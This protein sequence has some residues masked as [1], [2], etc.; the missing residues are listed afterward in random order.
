M[1]SR[2][3]TVF[4][5]PDTITISSG[6]Q[7]T[8][9]L[10]CAPNARNNRDLDITITYKAPSEKE[11]TT[12]QYKMCVFC[13]SPPSADFLLGRSCERT[14][15]NCQVLIYLLSSDL[16]CYFAMLRACYLRSPVYSRDVY[17]ARGH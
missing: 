14:L 9:Q 2:R 3:Q 12:I 13:F 15:T 6:E 4:Y 8:G 7:I 1:L 17:C 10:T 16:I 5:T 11:P